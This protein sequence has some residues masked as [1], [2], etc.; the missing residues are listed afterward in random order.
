MYCLAE[1][2]ENIDV[3]REE[4]EGIRFIRNDEILDFATQH[5]LPIFVS[6]DGSL[7]DEIATVSMSIIAPNILNMDTAHEWQNRPAKVLLIR[8]WRLPQR[9]G[10]GHSCI[11]MAEAFGFIIGEYTIPSDLPII[12]VTD[13]NNA[14]ILQRNLKNKE[15]FTHRQLIRCIKQGI[16]QAIANHMDILTTKWPSKETLSNYALDMYKKGE[17]I[18]QSCE[19]MSNGQVCNNS[20]SS[21]L[22]L[23]ADSYCSDSSCNSD[24][25]IHTASS[26]NRK[27]I[28]IHPGAIYWTA[29][30]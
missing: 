28:L 4:L 1:G 17:E 20:D 5:N 10:T 25:T 3:S 2:N 24:S 15:S 16:D 21:S 13:S 22:T 26:N 19:N 12:Y 23:D 6:I 14:R 18:C 29:S 30:S 11:N 7:Q 27:K 9:W 8:S